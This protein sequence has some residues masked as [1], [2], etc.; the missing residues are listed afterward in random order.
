[1]SQQYPSL[2]ITAPLPVPVKKVSKIV[3][4]DMPV[5]SGN[6]GL[7][8]LQEVCRDFYVSLALF[9]ITKKKSKYLLVTEI[10]THIIF[11][12]NDQ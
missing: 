10:Q 1:M 5:S 6:W 8:S 9:T 2:P 7:V 12:Q 4:S 3:F 11:S